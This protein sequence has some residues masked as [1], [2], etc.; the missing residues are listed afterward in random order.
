VAGE[1]ER[2]NAMKRVEKGE[3]INGIAAA[4][5]GYVKL[6][7]QKGGPS[8]KEFADYLKARSAEIPVNPLTDLPPEHRYESMVFAGI[9]SWL[10]GDRSD[11]PHP[12]QVIP[13]G[14]SDDEG[15]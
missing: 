4:I 2:K 10:E 7:E 14:K 12:F 5:A 6:A 1:I 3:L 13:G 8:A 15:H 11:R 9:V